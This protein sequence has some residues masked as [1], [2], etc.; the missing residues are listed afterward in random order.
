MM[1]KITEHI[2]NLITKQVKDNGVVVWYD[3]EEAYTEVIEKLSIPDTTVLRYEDSFI[4]LRAQIEPFLEFIDEN[5]KPKPEC[6][7]PPRLIVY[8]PRVRSETNYALVEAEYAG[9]VM[10]PGANPWQRNTRLR[11]VAEQVFKKIAPD[12]VKDI[13]RQIDEGILSLEELDKLSEEVEGIATATIKIIFGTASA[14]DVAMAFAASTEHDKA[15]QTKKAM[16]ELGGL[17]RSEL[18]IEMDPDIE[19]EAGRKTLLRILFVT[20]LLS[21]IPEEVRPEMLSSIPCPKR[22]EHCNKGQHICG[23]WRNRMDFRE[24]YVNAAKAVEEELRLSG[25]KWPPEILFD[26]ETFPFIEGVLFSFAEQCILNGELNEALDLA[27]RRKSSFWA[28]QEPVYQ[29]R[30]KLIEDSAR[31][32]ILGHKLKEELKSTKTSPAD[33]IRL[34]AGGSD[35]WYV[36]DTC[37]RHLEGKYSSFELDLD[38]QNDELEEV[39]TRVRQGYTSTAEN[40]IEVFTRCLKDADF[41]IQDYSSQESIFHRH[42]APHIA[43]NEKAAYILVDA[44]RFEMGKELVDGLTDEFEVS[45]LPGIAQLPTITTVG[46][47]ALMPGAEK[48]LE[49]TEKPSGQISIGI[50]AATLKDRSSRIKYFEDSLKK[51][52]TACKL[53]EL[54]KPSKKRQAQIRE[55]EVVLVTSQEIDRWGEEA[56]GEDEVRLFMD[57]V[58]D[59]LRN[60]IRRLAALGVSYFVVTADHG[61]IFGETIESG[62]KMAP[63]GGKTVELHRRVWI[64]KGGKSGEGFIRVSASDLGLGGDLELAFPRSLSCFKSKG[65][66][67]AY[68]HGGISLQEIVIPVILLKKK[69]I[70]PHGLKTAV[71]EL[72]V[73]KPKITTRF[74][75]VTATYFSEGLFGPDELRVKTSVRSKRKDVGF[76]AMSAYGFEE[77]TKEI[78]LQKDKP[79]SITFMLTDVQDIKKV[80]IHVLDAISQVELARIEHIPVEIAI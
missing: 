16:P 6:E 58:L 20:D 78:I 42:M 51:K 43:Q 2:L 26:L 60:A 48:G 50:D 37:Y 45:L 56:G 23:V 30:W 38:G 17:F 67:T 15:I 41:V 77:G 59:K 54:I 5:G 57:E 18:G 31:V 49:L 73:G 9:V 34:Y 11:V 61:H 72:S 13:G 40:S 79:N 64:G 74:F 22:Q 14:V 3:P 35:P 32:L 21:G 66:S 4:A 55:C 71:V 7:A 80:A 46:M 63:P 39:I 53:S 62:M 8:V 10:E 25:F 27:K 47:A 29:L 68:F 52:L 65:G 44:L 36:L 28:L 19:L 33:M 69:E 12:S 75:S 70:A 24:A 76:V 1:G